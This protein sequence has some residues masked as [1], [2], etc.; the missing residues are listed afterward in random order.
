MSKTKTIILSIAVLVILLLAVAGILWQFEQAQ[1]V[2]AVNIEKILP[3]ADLKNQF[4]FEFDAVVV[5]SDFPNFII[6]SNGY[7][8]EATADHDLH[9][10]AIPYN[11]NEIQDIMKLIENSH[12]LE[13]KDIQINKE[14]KIQAIKKQ[15]NKFYMINL[16]ELIY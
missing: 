3:T 16:Y 6:E 13:C 1:P 15:D 10:L 2:N 11:Y 9:C 4:G 7:E 5:K 14:Y 12:K 8:L